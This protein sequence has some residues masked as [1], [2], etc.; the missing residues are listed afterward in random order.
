MTKKM[1]TVKNHGNDQMVDRSPCRHEQGAAL[2]HPSQPRGRTLMHD[3]PSAGPPCNARRQ[4]ASWRLRGDGKKPPTQRIVAATSWRMGTR[5]GLSY[6]MPSILGAKPERHRKIPEPY[7]GRGSFHAAILAFTAP[8]AMNRLASH[9][10]QLRG[11]SA[12]ARAE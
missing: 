9:G 3:V 10:R 12:T 4:H 5:S 11:F 7:G 6:P 1:G 2:N 8:V